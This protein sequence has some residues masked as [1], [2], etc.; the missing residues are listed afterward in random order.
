MPSSSNN[1]MTTRSISLLP[2]SLRNRDLYRAPLPAGDRPRFHIQTSYI[3]YHR[4]LRRLDG[5]TPVVSVFPFLVSM[6]KRTHRD[7]KRTGVE[8]WVRAPAEMIRHPKGDADF[9]LGLFRCATW[10]QGVWLDHCWAASVWYRSSQDVVVI[11][12]DP[13][14]EMYLEVARGERVKIQDWAKAQKRF[15]RGTVRG[16]N[17]VVSDVW[18]GGTNPL[19]DNQMVSARRSQSSQLI[20]SPTT[21]LPGIHLPVVRRVRPDGEKHGWR[22]FPSAGPPAG[23]GI[24]ALNVIELG[25]ALFVSTNTNAKH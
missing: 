10:F 25:Y 23:S 22:C 21:A 13:A 8:R 18:W 17:I 4:R 3:D 20:G 9:R 12:F 11:I 16:R 7:P 1:R 19:V 2:S 6:D 15:L 5:V 24:S 14:A